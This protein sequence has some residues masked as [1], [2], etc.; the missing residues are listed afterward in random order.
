MSSSIKELVE[1]II[2]DSIRKQV[3]IDW[4]MKSVEIGKYII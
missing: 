2:D 1:F 3:E 4:K